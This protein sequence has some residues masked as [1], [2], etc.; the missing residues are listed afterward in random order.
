MSRR[1]SLHQT[2]RRKSFCVGV[3][4]IFLVVF[5]LVVLYSE[6]YTPSSSFKLAENTV[7]ESDFVLFPSPS[8]ADEDVL[9]NAT[10]ISN[11]VEDN[12]LIRGA[13]GR[14]LFV[15]K[16]EPKAQAGGFLYRRATTTAEH[17]RQRYCAR[18]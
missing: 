18:D 15:G 6:I 13:A 1:T 5:F 7:S 11:M 9:L 10:L 3:G 8:V 17:E 4:T 14:F 16:C 2:G 12:P